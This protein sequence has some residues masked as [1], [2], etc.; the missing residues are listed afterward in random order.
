MD[1]SVAIAHQQPFVPERM[2]L[3]LLSDP[4]Y[5][6]LNAQTW[7]RY[8]AYQH[9]VKAS[10][11]RPAFHLSPVAGLLNDPNG[12]C[13]FA[14][15]YHLFYQWFPFGIAHGMKHWA[16]VRSN[17]LV[18][19]SAPS[20]AMTP[21]SGYDPRGVYSGAAFLH[22]VDNQMLLYFTGNLKY[23]G[24]KRDATQCVAT[25]F[26]DGKVT[27]NANNPLI[28]HVPEG[29]SGH[30]R[31][32]K[33]IVVEDG[34]RMLLGA[35][36]LGDK[37]CVLVYRSDDA[38]NWTLL[39][40]LEVAFPAGQEIGGYMWEC[41]D[42]FVLDGH[43]VL[44]F[45]PQ[46]IEPQGAR[47][48]NQFNVVYCLG[49]ADWNAL[50]FRVDTVE[51]F[52]RGFD[53]YAPQTMENNPD[54]KR[55]LCAWAGCGDPEFP[56]DVEGWSNCLTFPRELYIQENQLC[57]RPVPAIEKLYLSSQS[58]C[59]EVKGIEVITGNIPHR[60][61][62]ILTLSNLSDETLE[63][64][65]LADERESLNLL[66]DRA[67][68]RVTLD[69]SKMQHRFATAWGEQRDL[70]YTLGNSVQVDVLV[71]GSIVE[72]FLDGGRAAM[73]ARV[74]PTGATGDIRLLGSASAQYQ[75]ATHLLKSSVNTAP[76]SADV[77][78]K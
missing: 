57:Q 21:D 10:H 31:D 11:W 35:Q 64:Q 44:V 78:S 16:H 72:I 38:F 34:Y 15:E 36:T 1:Y 19:W 9:Q 33:V 52:D 46:G 51:E 60:Y 2:T 42:Y 77:L 13:Y 27:K 53:F 59:G 49:K 26:A 28:P 45:S 56:S 47:F 63:L 37:G 50:T 68:G 23:E 14:G 29:L 71:D 75:C 67:K 41:P 48:H 39:G 6:A 66:L 54:G 70:D 20:L 3:K 18:N 69:R 74:F 4:K 62:L 43:D 55:V 24:D 8:D 5:V 22:P 40:Q 30:V 58:G 12:F 25:L 76:I 7:P 17:D 61:R 32:P 73:T 65:L